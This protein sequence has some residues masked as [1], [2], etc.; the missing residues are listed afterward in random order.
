ME[1]RLGYW[2]KVYIVNDE[3]PTST[4]KSPADGLIKGGSTVHVPS[5]YIL[6]PS[7]V[8]Q[9]RVLNIHFAPT[10]IPSAVSASP[11]NSSNNTSTQFQYNQTQRGSPQSLHKISGSVFYFC[12]VMA[13]EEGVPRGATVGNLLWLY[14][15]YMMN[16]TW[17]VVSRNKKI[18]IFVNKT[19]MDHSLFVEICFCYSILLS[20]L[21]V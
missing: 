4:M 19:A 13:L 12:L 2:V 7:A 5:A 20:F 10:L 6:W 1:L 9:C 8:W 15:A 17:S 14:S 21:G 11:D 16:R 18:I 3:V